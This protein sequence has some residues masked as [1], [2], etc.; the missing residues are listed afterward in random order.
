MERIFRLVWAMGI[1]FAAIAAAQAQDV[2]V[3]PLAWFGTDDAPQELPARKHKLKVEF[4]DDLRKTP[5]VGWAM[6]DVSLDATGK[7]MAQPVYAT[8]P[9]YEVAVQRGD[10]DGRSYTPAKSAGQPVS[11]RVRMTVIFN[12]ASAGVKSPEAT[13]R[14]LDASAIFDPQWK[15][16][17]RMD[18]AESRVAWAEVDLDET[19]GVR[20]LRARDA[21]TTALLKANLSGWRFAPARR[22]GRAVAAS[23]RVPFILLPPA[24]EVSKDMVPPRVL[25]RVQPEYPYV[26]RRSGLRGEVLVEFVVDTQGLVRVATVVR[27]LNPAFDEPALKA[28]R[29]W[30][31]EPGRVRGRAV[32]TRMR[33][34]I[35]FGIEGLTDD[36]GDGMEMARRGKQSKLPEYLRYDTPPK[37]AATVLVRYPYSLLQ[38]GKSGEAEVSMLIGADGKVRLTKVVKA[39]TPEFGLA[40][41]AAADLF[42]YMPALKQ[43][44]PTMA[45]IAFQQD[46]RIYHS[47]LVTLE[48]KEA[49][50]LETKHPER[51]LKASQLDRPLKPR[52]LREPS[53]P[54]AASLG[55]VDRGQ[56]V[57][58]F[59]VD[60]KGFVRLP[61]IVSA[62]D[63]VF[64]YAAV[65]AVA[66]WEFEPPTSQGRPG[67][68]RAQ[69][70]IEFRRGAAP[71]AA[72]P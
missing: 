2:T 38:A 60:E 49:L 35:H 46:F 56:A 18:D 57:V 53:F 71:N 16:R 31:F 9:A 44:Q 52:A 28:V 6:F 27:S 37:T 34:S 65:Q 29:A 45:L 19:G 30:K 48:D 24:E 51:I 63:P 54:K 10:R 47:L 14:L 23:L 25:S 68:A 72:K 66:A 64:G 8:Q 13:P 3:A 20:D 70:P 39:T 33:Q 15:Q 12:P 69:V 43:G 26:M 7:V 22:A 11:A 62:S 36:G 41:Q 4:P 21:E 59:L 58:A 5:D 67:V 42:E 55:E 61:R 17:G 40:L 32:N 50:A 1:S